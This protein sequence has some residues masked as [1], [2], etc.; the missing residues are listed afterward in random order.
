MRLGTTF[1]GA[2]GCL[3]S[4]ACAGPTAHA[5][6]WE[7]RVVEAH[8][9]YG[10]TSAEALGDAIQ[11]GELLERMVVAHNRWAADGW[12][13]SPE[14]GKLGAG[15]LLLR[16]RGSNP[17]PFEVRF[18]MQKELEQVSLAVAQ[19]RI[20]ELVRQGWVLARSN[21]AWLEFHRVR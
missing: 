18:V 2:I 10:L 5:D 11:K 17:E 15:R 1:L 14:V 3:Y 8:A 19:D 9:F 7:Y 21:D 16:R 13:L 20:D 6:H 4:A 12:D